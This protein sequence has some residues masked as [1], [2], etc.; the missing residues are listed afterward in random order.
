LSKLNVANI[1]TLHAFCLQI[2]KQYYYVINLDPMF[3]MLTEDTEVALL[4]ENVWDDLDRKSTRLNSSHVS[5]SYAV[6]CLK[7]KTERVAKAVNAQ[8]QARL[9]S[10]AVVI[11]PLR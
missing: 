2:I 8:R 3:R 7:K 9:H 6:F 4:Q 10:T 11:E 1:S 5:I